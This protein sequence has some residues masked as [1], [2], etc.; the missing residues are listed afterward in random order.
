MHVAD[1][2]RITAATPNGLAGSW[3]IDPLNVMIGLA[4]QTGGTFTGGIWMPTAT[5]S[6][7]TT[8][9]IEA[10][11]NLGT[12]VTITT[13]NAGFAEAGDITVAAP[14]TMTGATATT[15]TLQADNNIL[16][17]AGTSI[18]STGGALN[19]TFNS[20]NDGVGGG[21]IYM[22][23]GSSIVSNGGNITLAGAP[24]V[25][26]AIGNGTITGGKTF[27]SGIYVLGNI[28]AGAGNVTMR[29]EGANNNFADGI[30]FAGGTL[31]SNGIVNIDGIAHGYSTRPSPNVFAAGVDFINAGTRLSTQTGTV[32]VTGTN[33]VAWSFGTDG[34]A[35]VMVETGTIVET[36]G[37]GTLNFNGSANAY[38]ASWG[39]GV[40]GGTIQTTAAGGGAITLNGTN[41]N[42]ADGG[43]VIWDGHVLSG[44]GAINLTG[45][46]SAGGSAVGFLNTAANTLTLGGASSGAITIQGL[47]TTGFIDFNP[48]GG[49]AH[50]INAGSSV[51]SI[52]SGNAASTLNNVQINAG[53]VTLS[54]TGAVKDNG[55]SSLIT[56]STLGVTAVGGVD[57]HTAVAGIT[58]SN[59]GAGNTLINNTGALT[60]SGMTDSL[61]SITLNNTGSITL[62]GAVSA[63]G[64]NLTASGTTSDINV[65]ASIAKPA[66]AAA[67]LTMLAGNN[68]NFG[69][70]A[71][72]GSGGGA[73]NVV[74]HSDS[75][76]SGGGTVNFGG[77]NTFSLLGGRVD[78][79]YNPVSYSDAATK[80]DNFG[81]PYSAVFG[82]NPY[83]AWMLVNDVGLETGGTLG[84]QAMSTN[85]AGNY[86]LGKD[87]AA[88]TS[89]W[90]AGAGFAPVGNISTPFTGRF[91]G[92]GHTIDGLTIN[93]PGTEYIGLFGYLN[94]GS[95][96]SNVALTNV[97]ITGFRYVG[98]L[99]GQNNGSIT[100]SSVGGNVSGSA[101]HIGGLVG[102]NNGSITTSNASANV[103]GG[104]YVG[105]LVGWAN[106]SSS[107]SFSSAS[108]NVSGS[109]YV[110]GLVGFN[111]NYASLTNS[112]AS[113]NV[114][115][116]NYIGGLVG[117]TQYTNII[118]ST[119]SGNVTG[120]WWAAG[121]LVGSNFGST[122]SNSSATGNV[123]GVNHVGGLVGYNDYGSSVSGN[124]FWT[125]TAGN[126]V[127][128]QTNVGGLV[129]FNAGSVVNSTANGDVSGT[130]NVG[131]LVGINQYD[132]DM[133]G[134]Y[135]YGTV[136]NSAATGNVT[137]GSNVGG[138]VG[139]NSNS[140]N[141]INASNASGSVTGNS[142]VGG[143]VG[144]N[145]YAPVSNSY[146]SG[147]V[148]GSGIASNNL[149]G[150]VGVNYFGTIDNAYATGSVT[151]FDNLG[152][153]VGDNFGTISNSYVSIG[154]VT[155]TLS[156]GGLVGSN[157][158]TLTNSHYNITDVLIN[159]GHHV[160]LGGLYND[161]TASFNNVGQYTDW[162]V[163]GNKSL[164]I[165]N[166]TSPYGS[167]GT[168]AAGYTISNTQ[169]LKDLLG[170]S[171]NSLYTFTLTGTIDLT[172]MAG[173]YIPILASSFDGAGIT[174]SNL[175]LN[176][177]TSYLGFFGKVSGTSTVS[178]MVLVDAAVTGSGGVGVLAGSNQ[179]TINNSSVG[180]SIGGSVSVSGANSVGGLVGANS[181]TIN[182]GSV[183]ANTNGSVTVSGSSDVGG[184]A[185]N[186]SGI[187]SAGS[188]SVITNGSVTVSG[189]FN[190]GGLAG[191]HSGSIANSYVSSAAITASGASIGG[192][193]GADLGTRTNSHFNI[194]AVTTNG[195]NNV[196]IAGLYTN[197]YND[198]LNVGTPLAALVITDYSASL[199]LQGD[200]SY[201]I[202][203][204]QGMKDML[205]F[206]DDPAGYNFSLLSPNINLIAG[207]YV[208]KLVGS[209][210]GNNF[211]LSNL[212]LTLPNYDMG[213]F[214]VTNTTSL[215]SNLSLVNA[216]VNGYGNVGG[217][218]GSNYGNID[219]V[220]V[221][222]SA[223]GISA[224]NNNVGGLV[225]QN[226]G[227]SF[228]ALGAATFGNISNSYVS[229][230]T[231]TGGN[232]NVG[233][234]V[235][236]NSWGNID[237]SG[238]DNTAVSGTSNVGGLVGNNQA[239]AP[240]WSGAAQ[241]GIITNS[242][243]SGGSVTGTGGVL[244]SAI[245][246]LVG[247]NFNGNISASHVL[248]ANVNG[249]LASM[250]GGLVG[251]NNGRT[252]SYW[253]WN[254]FSS[255]L[256]TSQSGTISNSYVSSGTVTSTGND[257]GGLVGN[258]WGASIDFGSVDNVAVTGKINVG[259]LVGND[260]GEG[261][262]GNSRLGTIS[263][264]HTF[265]TQVT[266]ES[267]VGGL[268]GNI[269]QSA[270]GWYAS[271]DAVFN[272]YVDLGTVT[273]NAI[274]GG[275]LVTGI[276][277]LV[278][279]NGYGN[280]SSS[281]V[282]NGTVVSGGVAS[283]VGG[284][285]GYNIG[286]SS[287]T[288]TGLGY[289]TVYRGSISNSYVS[290]GTVSGDVHVGGLVG[291]NASFGFNDIGYID[292]S[293]ALTTSVTGRYAV[294]GLVGSSDGSVTNSYVITPTVMATSSS[295]SVWAGGLV[296]RNYGSISN[297]YVSGGTVSA[298]NFASDV[299]GLVGNNSGSISNGYASGVAVSASNSV[300]GLVGDNSGSISNS[301]VSNGSVTG[302]GRLVGASSSSDAVG[303][304]I[305]LNSGS[306]SITN[307]YVSNGTISNTHLGAGGLVGRNFGSVSNSYISGGSVNATYSGGLAFN[308][309]GIF[310]NSFWDS[311]TTLGPWSDDPWGGG[312]TLTN[313]TGIAGML[314]QATLIGL[315]FDFTPGTGTWYMI[316]G[317]TRPF[318]QSEWSTNIVN[319]HQ[320]Q[321]IGMNATTLA[322]SYT[323]ANNI[324][325]APAL[326]LG[327]MWSSA[328]FVPLGD[329]NSFPYGFTGSLDGAN[330]TISNLT[331]NR[332]GQNNVGLIGSLES[333]GVVSNIGLINPNVTGTNEVGALVG[334]SSPGATMSN[335]YVIGGTVSGTKNVGGMSGKIFG[336]ILNSYASGVAVSG[337]T[338]VGG[339]VGANG[340]TSDM[341]NPG[342]AISNSY[343][344]G[345][346]VAGTTSIGG[347]AGVN[348]AAVSD[349]F[350]DTQTTGQAN[351]FGRTNGV[352][353]TTNVLGLTTSQM[354]Q[355]SNFTGWD[356]ANTWRIYNGHTA[357]LLKSFL[358]PVTV[359][360]SG[361]TGNFTKTYD[362]VAW[363]APALGTITY[364][365]PTLN[366][367]LNLLNEATPF[368][369]P[370]TNAGS[371]EMFWSGQQGYDITYTAGGMLT[372]NPVAITLLSLK[373]DDATKTYGSILN[374]A[375]T[376]FSLTS[377]TL[378]GTDN[379]SSVTMT[380]AG[381]VNTAN[382][383]AYDIVV[384]PGSEV[385]S[386]GNA[387]NY[388]ITYVD[389]TLT[390]NA[391]PLILGAVTDSK[392]YDGT[393]SSPVTPVV[394]SGLV[395]SD[396][397]TGITQA[398]GSKHVLGANG[399]TLN[400]IG[401]TVN[402]VNGGNVGLNYRVS[403]NTA[404]GTITAI[405]LTVSA[406]GVNRFY[407]GTTVASVNLSDTR[408][409]G[410]V[411]T[412][413]YGAANFQDKNI[414]T[415]KQVDVTGI[416][417]S[418]IDAGNYTF[419][420]TA[421][422]FADISA[423]ALIVTGIPKNKV[424]GTS[425]PLLTYMVT[426]LYDPIS[427]VLTGEL[428]RDL[429]ESIGTYRVNQGSLALLSTNY[430]LSYVPCN[431]NILAPT[432]VQEIT[433]ISL[434]DMPK[435]RNTLTSDEE[436]ERLAEEAIASSATTAEGI[437]S[438]AEGQL[439]VCR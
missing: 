264:S 107:V 422:T 172:G 57:L 197:Q 101:T 388:N 152:G 344:S 135:T 349:S 15:L 211:T 133:Y 233:G 204:L 142:G 226:N 244:S 215:V 47:G 234:L 242:Y 60:V 92:L 195:G 213:L 34:A 147:N 28:T 288:W 305:G 138:L 377:G 188:L 378:V 187:I 183:S 201:G 335:N 413:S 299:G 222:V 118:N 103:S 32:T 354:Q 337:T 192:L 189:A 265:N 283:N 115:G 439:P 151:G 309:S 414:G 220:S 227:G 65:N 159:G 302:I 97:S 224:V 82:G 80:S 385:F 259:G 402:D 214:G 76:G 400:V 196:T 136:S 99:A 319:A 260:S 269:T 19:V 318:L 158:G 405:P 30:T 154:S 393:T 203:T 345:G 17:T 112:S 75:D 253:S 425:D 320:L 141:F 380:S 7:I 2:A 14:V 216:R 89:L 87:F 108:G 245:G 74:M 128:G 55:I 134:Y 330:F 350:W 31:S 381:A 162:L 84:L 131:G 221:G 243:V 397:V 419:N 62:S 276:G 336:D 247:L 438:G 274:T 49:F 434:L 173:F 13:A 275:A 144:Y 268:I 184:L 333:T 20:N 251:S 83:T 332:P 331:I 9:T 177:P 313:S 359:G 281:Y 329:P 126:T 41:L 210:N 125:P 145:S 218:V 86:A 326:A 120:T 339:L 328:G 280:I 303:G 178:N 3:L 369:A 398:F 367:G 77:T 12:N 252:V 312:G 408:L 35:G 351:A 146:A 257:V 63:N 327:G 301:Y 261:S 98:G 311:N 291:N 294:G 272:S 394:V 27:N 273:G 79:Y 8:G 127:S 113:G 355:E 140:Y 254:G 153:L 37:A 150:L 71:G 199:V 410:D 348:G 346:S 95:S 431:F 341:G 371:Y 407:N 46:T 194:D 428:A 432:V 48:N 279:H 289:G 404:T 182:T 121:G 70:G 285:V 248:N 237:L 292:S 347:L 122:V 383:G 148:I 415:T 4:G 368:G 255:V 124:S 293:Y 22:D 164:N 236:Y 129:G 193:I 374:F 298:L 68:I 306:G 114:S 340:S 436:E 72:I 386:V 208:P 358:T 181:G 435:D 384:T 186:N 160:T 58:T 262:Y 40:Y 51:F 59:T 433:E 317:S 366:V 185:G 166:Y 119:A 379:I 246:G 45:Q 11:L 277:G 286:S 282:T 212:S 94:A 423:A 403:L 67:T 321:L 54:S 256:V 88:A 175:S 42:N 296:G 130:S 1:T 395:N 16:L 209:F 24:S 356:F 36:T 100:N 266:G 156:V 363:N 353:S 191:Y 396:S 240:Y 352:N 365:D 111:Y 342:G 430:T 143:L 401:Y 307:S 171:D 174:I 163:N 155:G 232:A 106:T 5:G 206:A 167:F 375:G 270:S 33:T 25:G 132:F 391:A 66:G 180:T 323:L 43:V 73:L 406:S 399:S 50:V 235:G 427:S 205:G 137:G 310:T 364:S 29:G 239:S 437:I 271:Y 324:D 230:G 219:N 10:A 412:A 110:G 6:F 304:L 411:L 278:G 81:N 390:V 217:L 207:Y 372:I 297:S 109:S 267:H 176:L 387:S 202:G 117:G 228:T 52:S 179:G 165:A 123:I 300:G 325:L 200:G 421:M 263:N 392:Q 316:D 250:V 23:T 223:G 85:L 334:Q 360:A 308:N 362:A 249:G 370:V 149:G 64:L 418:G 21:G 426:G 290:G 429:G 169:G 225:G 26:Y 373:A 157:T 44:G 93:R 198:W 229:G 38:G 104:D 338:N 139:S 170:F 284:L 90:N 420:T 39:V 417:L 91:D 343:V 424:L 258:N 168:D 53:S 409:A 314:N 416:S 389:G 18:S 322:A 357:P 61:G 105:G 161:N 96:V 102:Y 190:V 56:A 361:I 116:A 382:V 287:T 238:V 315:G 241:G 295:S 231:V 69:I 376:E 78:L